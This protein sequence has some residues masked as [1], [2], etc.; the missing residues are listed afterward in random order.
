MKSKLLALSVLAA[1]P[2]AAFA[3]DGDITFTG[4]IVD[5]AC[6][7][8]GFNNETNKL[9]TTMALET[10]TPSSFR[11]GTNSYAGMKNF[12]VDLKD[13]S[14][15]AATNAVVHFSGTPDPT[16]GL[17]LKNISTADGAA[18]GVGIAIL[19]D[20]GVSLVDI[21]GGTAAR[22]QPLTT[23]N[24]VLHYKVAYKASDSTPT[25]TAGPISAK[26]YIDIAYN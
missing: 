18:G 6:T 12:T 13:C 5:T 4:Q 1:L 11:S 3:G 17:I 9:S 16:N 7:F 2:G 10:V 14:T 25:V 8:T 26:A 15:T 23:G 19:E 24:T 22:A 21:N 20:D